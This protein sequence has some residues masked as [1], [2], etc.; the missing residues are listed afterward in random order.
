VTVFLTVYPTTVKGDTVMRLTNVV[1]RNATPQEKPY[2]LVD[3]RGLYVLVNKAGKYFRW[4]YRFAG[5]RKTLALGVYPEISLKEAREK[6][7]DLRRMLAR[8]ID[9]MEIKKQKK[10]E[11]QAEVENTFEFVAREWFVKNNAVWTAKHADTIISRLQN[12]IFP[13]LGFVEVSA[14]TAPM[15]LEVLRR[16][17]ERGALETAHRV[18]QICGQVFRYAVATGRAERDPSFDLRGAL[19]PTKSKSMATI[20]DP[21]K[22]GVLMR[23]IDGYQGSI[24]TRCAL[25]FAPLTFVRPGEL[26]HAEWTEFNLDEFEWKIPSEKMKMRTVHIVPL[27]LQA[28]T[29]LKE[30]RPLTGNGKYVFP[31]LRSG[32]RPMSN[33]TILAALRSMGYTKEEMTGHGFRAMASTLLHEQGWSSDVIERQ[34]AHRE[35]NS[36]KA[37][38]NHA[39]YLPE[40]R[41]MMQVWADYL[42]SLRGKE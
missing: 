9:P 41:K 42:D 10:A 18:K 37:A 14:V 11:I 5:K 8:D 2:K 4:D 29:V 13:W 17:E 30:I 23:A 25:K 27:S 39:Q 34:L 6:H 20:T 26:R 32:G 24:I 35:R 1:V 40:R 28:I 21:K 38:Y 33:N 12:N 22:I 31:S 3:G 16:I 36:V 19:A 7:E 15:L